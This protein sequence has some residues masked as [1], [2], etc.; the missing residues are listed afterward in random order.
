MAVKVKFFIFQR[1]KKAKKA[2]PPKKKIKRKEEVNI[3]TRFSN[4]RQFD[5]VATTRKQINPTFWN[6]KSGAV[7][8]ISEFDK[9]DEFQK[10]LNELERHILDEFDETSD[11]NMI[12]K[13][14]LDITIDKFY[15]EEKYAEE[16]T[17]LFNY[18]Q[19]FIELS[20]SRTNPNTGNP[21]SYRMQREYHI[22]FNYL[23]K[24]A[25]KFGEPD[26]DDIN[27]DFYNKYTDFLRS[28]K[29]IVWDK[30]GNIV[31]EKFLALN[32]VGKKII[33]LKIFLNAATEEGI[34]KNYRYK[35]RSF[36][37][38][39]EEA[40]NIYLTK[41][42]LDKFYTHDFSKKPYLERVRDLF[43]VGSWTGLRYSDLQQITPDKIKG[44]FIE[45]R[46]QKTGQKVIIPVHQ[47]VREIL[48]K[49]NG[50]LP[51]PISNQKFNDYLKDAAELTE[52]DDIF[53]KT[54]SENGKKV[55]KRYKKHEIISSHTARRSFCTNAYIDNIPTLAIMAIS[56]HRTEKAFL[57]YIKADGREHA[58]KILEK[59]MQNNDATD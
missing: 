23:K 45:L 2:E 5:V 22:T 34:N 36:K 29:V 30:E 52:L 58:Q 8:D 33:T 44:N 56:G 49:Y 24:Y 40:D 17:T 38:P 4:G 14:W 50:E 11:K 20:K 48:D 41:E 27:L 35:S 37:A 9:R 3:L 16:K 10:K 26:F 6:N 46:Q 32:T 31:K 13:Q 55:E 54:T 19:N 57:K 43:I 7:R 59:W 42:E 28:Q 25:K 12:D 18:I 47:T 1:N 51:E 21:V 53:I 39:S 15:N